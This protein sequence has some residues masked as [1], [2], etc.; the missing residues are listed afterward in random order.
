MRRSFDV[1]NEWAPVHESIA[2]PD[3]FVIDEGFL[4]DTS[5][6]LRIQQRVAF[7]LQS[8]GYVRFVE[9]ATRLAA[10]YDLDRTLTLR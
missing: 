7:A 8:R 6:F 2:G 4:V 1:P 3:I 9:G 5:M 10:A